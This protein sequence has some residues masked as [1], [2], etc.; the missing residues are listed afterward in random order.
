MILFSV[1]DTYFDWQALKRWT[2][3]V[4]V[5]IERLWTDTTSFLNLKNESVLGNFFKLVYFTE[6]NLD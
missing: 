4:D 1:R 3:F 6:E 5:M 2:H